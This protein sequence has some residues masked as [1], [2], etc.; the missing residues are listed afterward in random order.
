MIWR[1]LLLSLSVLS[2]CVAFALFSCPSLPCVP[3]LSSSGVGFNIVTG[4]PQFP[5]VAF[6]FSENRTWVSQETGQAFAVPDQAKVSSDPFT[7]TQSR[8]FRSEY[9]FSRHLTERAGLFWS[10][11]PFFSASEEMASA[12]SMMNSGSSSFSSTEDSVS[13]HRISLVPETMLPTTSNFQSI[14][15][16]LPYQ[17][18]PVAYGTFV[19]TFGTHVLMDVT[20]GGKAAWQSSVASSYSKSYTDFVMSGNCQIDYKWI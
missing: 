14:I 19:Q 4:K 5:V 17:Y 6:S 8:T 16:K 12:R 1:S 15:S 3:G 13:L 9:E 2:S 7:G 18:D 10:G 20:L 11:L